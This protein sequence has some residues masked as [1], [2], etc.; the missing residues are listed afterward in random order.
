ML[1]VCYK[2]DI[3]TDENKQHTHVDKTYCFHELKKKLK[4]LIFTYVFV[5]NQLFQRKE[6]IIKSNVI[7]YS[8]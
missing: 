4:D 1:E 2:I 6:G 7:P 5:I 8:P 3:D